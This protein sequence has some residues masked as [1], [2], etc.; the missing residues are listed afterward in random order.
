[1][2]EPL[3]SSSV[4]PASA[5]EPQLSL[6]QRKQQLV[7]TLLKKIEQGYV[8]ES[9][10]ETDAVLITKGRPKRW[11]GLVEGGPSTRQS[12]SIDGQG[13]ASMRSL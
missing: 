6:E 9:Q 2:A 3:L 7:A 10:T 8:V 4:S 5:A 13:S 1:M 12:I 11:F